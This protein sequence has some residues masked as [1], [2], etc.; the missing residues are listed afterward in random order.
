M[1]GSLIVRALYHSTT[2]KC[3]WFEEC[4]DTKTTIACGNSKCWLDFCV[5][6]FHSL[7]N[8][9]H[10]ERTHSLIVRFGHMVWR[11]QF[12]LQF[13]KYTIN[14]NGS[15]QSYKLIVNL[16]IDKNNCKIDAKTILQPFLCFIDDH[17]TKNI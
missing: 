3:W 11:T 17:L 8:Q 12:L 4:N 9:M 13:L 5:V 10:N 16:F 6:I 2:R 15:T 1:N 7:C 14:L